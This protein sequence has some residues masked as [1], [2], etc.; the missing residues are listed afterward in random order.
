MNAHKNLDYID[1]TPHDGRYDYVVIWLHGLGADG[2]DFR[3]LPAQLNLAPTHA[4]RFV[5]PHAPL[6]P[7]TINNGFVMRAWYDVHHN[8]LTLAPDEQGMLASQQQIHALIDD[9]I[10]RGV[11]AENII[12]GGFSQGGAIA[13]LSALFYSQKIAGVIS[14]SS[15]LPAISSIKNASSNTHKLPVLI[16]HGDADAVVPL[17]HGQQCYQQLLQL[18][19]DVSW[20]QYPMEHSLCQQQINDIADWMKN[21]LQTR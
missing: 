4:I 3:D 18:G 10:N 2:A 21:R 6:R 16:A 15:Y 13:L 5:F 9:E 12:L 11:A 20:F 7:V 17:Q 19:C 1:I 14:L 8:N